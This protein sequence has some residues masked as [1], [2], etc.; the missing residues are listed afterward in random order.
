MWED[1]FINKVTPIVKEG[2]TPSLFIHGQNEESLPRKWACFAN[3]YEVDGET[4]WFFSGNLHLLLGA[5]ASETRQDFMNYRNAVK[6]KDKDAIKHYRDALQSVVEDAAI[7]FNEVADMKD[8][9]NIE[10][11][12][13]QANDIAAKL[14]A[15]LRGRVVRIDWDEESSKYAGPANHVCPIGI[16]LEDGKGMFGGFEIDELLETFDASGPKTF[17]QQID[18]ANSALE[19]DEDYEEELRRKL[20][21]EGIDTKGSSSSDT[22]DHTDDTGDDTDDTD[23]DD[24]DTEASED[25]DD[26]DESVEDEEPVKPASK[27]TTTSSNKTKPSTKKKPGKKTVPS[28]DEDD[29]P[30]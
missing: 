4:R 15:Y 3:S 28:G 8:A 14:N 26:S 16:S 25:S 12:R 30:F 6:E 22:D 23:G 7:R 1:V 10:E 24:G 19:I 2:K 27:K 17:E 5:V 20:E 13:K 11:A 9:G 29:I 21:E 18:D